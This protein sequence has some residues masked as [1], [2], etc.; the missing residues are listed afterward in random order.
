MA[1]L[2]GLELIIMSLTEESMSE[3]LELEYIA[4]SSLLYSVFVDQDLQV[5]PLQA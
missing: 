5:E 2:D 4:P 3:L 1:F